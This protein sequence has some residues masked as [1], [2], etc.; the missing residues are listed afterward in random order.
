MQFSALIIRVDI[1]IGVT[2]FRKES[3]FLQIFVIIIRLI[4]KYITAI[5][6]VSAVRSKSCNNHE[7]YIQPS[8]TMLPSVRTAVADE[9]YHHN[10]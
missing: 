6:A 7:V 5:A 1:Y 4:V 8:L 10:S 9:L 3:K 2:L